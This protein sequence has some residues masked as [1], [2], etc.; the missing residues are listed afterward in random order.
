MLFTSL[1][2]YLV[3]VA[4]SYELAVKVLN[5]NGLE[6]WFSF[7]FLFL[8]SLSLTLLLFYLIHSFNPEWKPFFRKLVRTSGARWIALL[9]LVLSGSALLLI[10]LS[11]G[12]SPL[13]FGLLLPV[14]LVSFVNW[15]GIGKD[16][17]LLQDEDADPKLITLK[18]P[19]I[20]E[21]G[22]DFRKMFAWDY[23]GQ[24]YSLQLVVRRA[25]YDNFKSRERIEFGSEW[26]REYVAEGICGE[27]RELANK[28][29]TVNRQY[30]TYEEVSFILAFVQS[31][32][33]YRLEEGEYPKYPVET[34]VDAAGDCEDFSILGAAILKVMGYDVA[35][36]HLPGHIAL[37]V[38]GAD[39][40]PGSYAEHEGKRY[41]YCEMTA[42]GWE[43]GQLPDDLAGTQIQV[44]PVP[45]MTIKIDRPEAK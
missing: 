44:L 45:G 25:F 38:A 24:P 27:V 19:E 17:S 7:L 41:Y 34:L 33:E 15:V 43:I 39:G 29:L 22:E 14:S 6:L 28:L 18:D 26:A 21:V 1:L 31:V 8:M 12:I 36:L 37:G 30:G 2:I 11:R 32:I 35:L 4:P 42:K 5:L 9:T 40:I 23:E 13:Y 3:L 16:P 10:A 20:T